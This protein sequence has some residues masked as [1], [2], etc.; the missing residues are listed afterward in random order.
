MAAA[1]GVS[2]IAPYYGRIDSAGVDAAKLIQDIAKL[3][4]DHHLDTKIAAASLRNPQQIEAALL[5]GAHVIV[6]GYA[7]Y[8]Q[9]L[10]NDLTQAWIDGFEKDWARFTFETGKA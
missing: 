8:Q 10:D 2:Y 1:A 4:A 5:A 9:M 7:V 6:T 3:Y